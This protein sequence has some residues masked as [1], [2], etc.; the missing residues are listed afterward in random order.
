MAH[1]AA[2]RETTFQRGLLAYRAGNHYDAHEIWEELWEN[3]ESD[4]HRRFLQALIQVTSALHKLL[5]GV[6]PRGSLRLLD[7]ARAKLE[8]LPDAYGGVALGRFRE[9][10]ERARGEFE[11]LIAEGRRDLD[12]SFIPPL[13]GVGE[14]LAWQHRPREVS[15][16]ATQAVRQGLAAYQ[17][18]RF[19]DAHA[20]WEDLRQ[21]EP[22]GTL[23]TFLQGLILIAAAMHKLFQMKSPP[24]ALKML[25]LAGE[26]LGQ[27]PEG[28]CGI[29]VSELLSE[30]ARAKESLSRLCA[31]VPDQGGS[32]SEPLGSI[33]PKI[34]RARGRG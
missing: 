26:R 15:P 31:E 16:D 4:D 23:R 19:Y 8:G 18:G 7:S 12:P 25:E 1:P 17:A 33:A 34:T 32:I 20:I 11:R 13:E 24:G 22:E 14:A 21:H 28:T 6:G 2:E 29:A 5:H 27:A 10:I 3:E 30:I 9:G